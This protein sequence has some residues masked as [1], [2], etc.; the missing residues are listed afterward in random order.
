[1]FAQVP[2]QRAG[3]AADDATERPLG[4]LRCA[5]KKVPGRTIGRGS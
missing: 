4:S 3:R 1:M 5:A 2:L